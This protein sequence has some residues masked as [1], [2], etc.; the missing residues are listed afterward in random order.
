MPFHSESATIELSRNRARS[1]FSVWRRRMRQRA[2]CALLIQASPR[3]I[4]LLIM[5]HECKWYKSQAI[6]D[7]KKKKKKDKDLRRI[8]M[9]EESRSARRRLTVR[10]PCA[11]TGSYIMRLW[12]PR[13]APNGHQ[14]LIMTT[15][16]LA[17]SIIHDFLITA[18][19]RN[20]GEEGAGGYICGGL[21]C[22]RRWQWGEI[23]RRQLAEQQFTL[24]LCCVWWMW[25]ARGW[26]AGGGGWEEGAGVFFKRQINV[27]AVQITFADVHWAYKMIPPPPH[28]GKKS[29][30]QTGSSHYVCYTSVGI[31]VISVSLLLTDPSHKSYDEISI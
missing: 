24:I 17:Y 20:G 30:L 14:G 27:P 26:A 22:R 6:R 15:L 1:R 2:P 7:K 5:R 10:E 31:N 23:R 9:G 12:K 28:V 3:S 8:V 19:I 29:H 18:A 4:R 21:A 16:L 11:I 13:A 25:P